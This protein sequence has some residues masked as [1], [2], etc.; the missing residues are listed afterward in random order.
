MLSRLVETV[1]KI[2][3]IKIS[4]GKY[5]IIIIILFQFKYL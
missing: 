4:V 3:K 2:G 5:F 1:D